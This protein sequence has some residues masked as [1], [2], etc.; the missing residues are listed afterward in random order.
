MVR[1][2][3]QRSKALVLQDGRRAER[4]QST[5]CRQ[6]CRHIH[7]VGTYILRNILRGVED[8]VHAVHL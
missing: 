3:V 2:A 4:K 5:H 1:Q 7:G 8:S 6:V